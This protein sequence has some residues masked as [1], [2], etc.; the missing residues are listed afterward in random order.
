MPETDPPRLPDQPLGSARHINANGS[1]RRFDCDP[2]SLALFVGNEIEG[3][4]ANL[5]LRH[6]AQTCNGCRCWGLQPQPLSRRC[7][8]RR[9]DRQRE[10]L[11]IRYSIALVLAADAPAW[12]WHVRLENSNPARSSW[13]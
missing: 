10:W 9:A 2:I 1:L 11:G 7:G 8:H 6:H 13:I 12:F 5:Y 3:G 4:P